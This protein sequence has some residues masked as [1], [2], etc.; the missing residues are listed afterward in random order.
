[1]RVLLMALPS[2]LPLSRLGVLVEN[3]SWLLSLESFDLRTERWRSLARGLGG[4]LLDRWSP[5]GG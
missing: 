3:D 1:M 4:K 2:P 5:R